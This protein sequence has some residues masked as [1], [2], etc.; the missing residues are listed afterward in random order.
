MKNIGQYNQDL[1]VPRKKD[2]DS[3]ETRVKTNEDNI[4]MAESDIEGLNTDVGTLKTDVNNVKT[5]LSSKQ[6]TIVGAASTIVEDNLDAG[7]ILVSDSSGKVGTASTG[8]LAPAY[9]K[10]ADGSQVRT[11]YAE[12]T[13]TRTTLRTKTN[14]GVFGATFELSP[15]SINLSRF[16]PASPY[17][18]I[19]GVADAINTNDAVNLKQ[20]NEVKNSIPSSSD[21]VKTSGGAVTGPLYLFGGTGPLAVKNGSVKLNEGYSIGYGDGNYNFTQISG[22][23]L[24]S[25]GDSGQGVY[26]TSGT[27]GTNGTLS[28]YVNNDNQN[29]S[30]YMTI[31]SNG[32][33]S[34]SA[35]ERANGSLMVNDVRVTGV[36]DG[37]ADKDAVNLGQLNSKIQYSTTDLTAGSSSLATG[38]LYVVYE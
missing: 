38:T 10:V 4:A 20:L 23:F 7:L 24:I 19:T 32:V 1:S 18:S 35:T 37:T 3:L 25:K 17:V 2:I 30:T 26:I 5:A 34:L 28:V 14:D 27:D 22:N 33:I 29:A 21:F 6:D 8:M 15:T 13:G 12:F 11:T 9:L 16:N 31:A 36:A